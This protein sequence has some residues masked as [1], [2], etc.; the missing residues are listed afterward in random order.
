MISKRKSG[1]VKK[2]VAEQNAPP[3]TSAI[4]YLVAFAVTGI[5]HHPYDPEDSRA[6][7]RQQLVVRAPNCLSLA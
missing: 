2:R 3:D 4:W 7:I 6:N 1:A 5:R